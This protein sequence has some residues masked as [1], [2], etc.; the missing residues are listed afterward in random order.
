MSRRKLG[1]RGGEQALGVSQLLRGR[2]K[3]TPKA[4]WHPLFNDGS[5]TALANNGGLPFQPQKFNFN[6]NILFLLLVYQGNS[7]L[8]TE[9]DTFP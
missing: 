3:I 2:V 1:H 7:I 8:T 4:S 6:L 5:K 9:R